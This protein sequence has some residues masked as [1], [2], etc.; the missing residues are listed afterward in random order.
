MVND[1]QVFII[2]REN[3]PS[4]ENLTG[5]LLQEEERKK[6]MDS[7][8]QSADSAAKDKMSSKGKQWTKNKGGGKFDNQRHKD[9]KRYQD[10]ASSKS[11][12]KKNGNCNYCGKFG[13]YAYECRKK[14]YN[15]S[16]NNKYEG[17]FVSGE[18]EQSDNLHNLKLFISDVA[19]SANVDDC[20]NWFID[21]GASI[22]MSCHRNWFKKIYEKNDGSK[23]YLGDDSSHDIKGYGDISVQLPNGNAK[24]LASVMYVR[25][26]KK[27]L[28]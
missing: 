1:Y 21:S 23:I 17:N 5:I 7:R 28:I 10:G 8:I 13:H 16:K 25:G 22:H 4:F 15:E 12:V 11:N 14:K 3:A 18:D 26:I 20:N 24:Q 2:L 9:A 19:L 27:K 6:H